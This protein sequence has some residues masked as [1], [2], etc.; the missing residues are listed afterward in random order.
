M[1]AARYAAIRAAFELLWASHLPGLVRRFSSSKGVIFTLHRVLPEPPAP[2]SP[3]RHP[4][5]HAGLPPLRHRACPAARP[6]GRLPRRGRD[7][8]SRIPSRTTPFA[9]FTFDDGYRDNRTTRC[10]CCAAQLPLHALHSDRPGRRRR[11]SL[12]AGARGR[13]PPAAADRHRRGRVRPQYLVTETLESR[14]RTSTTRS[15]PAC[16]RCRSPSG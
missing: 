9:V 13:H 3:E 15:T 12:V 8:G 16:A 4:P 11:R 6:R 1:G 5:G 14:S 2:F 10:R 7:A